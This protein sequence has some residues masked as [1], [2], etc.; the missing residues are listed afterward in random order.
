MPCPRLCRPKIREAGSA[1]R[2]R[3]ERKACRRNMHC[4]AMPGLPCPGR[5]SG[6]LSE[7][8]SSRAERRRG[9]GVIRRRASGAGG[10]FPPPKRAQ[11]QRL[12]TRDDPHALPGL[13]IVEDAGE[14]AAQFDRGRQ[15]AALL[16]DGWQ[17][18]RPRTRR[19]CHE[20]GIT[21]PASA[22]G[23]S[24]TSGGGCLRSR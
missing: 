11:R 16:V 3:R 1:P 7:G 15:L 14:A 23:I 6:D 10:R 13:G 22:S 4:R 21:V 12:P 8:P 9:R 20:H 18:P 2:D 19:T 5:Q 24:V 17:Q